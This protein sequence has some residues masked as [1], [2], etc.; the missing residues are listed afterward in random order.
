MDH[1]LTSGELIRM[2]TNLVGD[3]DPMI[4]TLEANYSK[5]VKNQKSFCKPKGFVIPRG[6]FRLRNSPNISST[7]SC[8][9]SAKPES[10]SPKKQ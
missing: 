9:P 6:P 3:E 5:E 1:G 2:T 10:I 8:L 4:P 7:R